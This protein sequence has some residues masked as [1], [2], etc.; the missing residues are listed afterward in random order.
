M[1]RLE[2]RIATMTAAAVVPA[3]IIRGM[4]IAGTHLKLWTNTESRPSSAHGVVER[5]D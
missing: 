5:S 3:E 2:K 1:H 4:F